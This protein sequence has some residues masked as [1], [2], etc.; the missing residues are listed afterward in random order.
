MLLLL[1]PHVPAC[2][3]S[4]LLGVLREQQDAANK[5]QQQF[6]AR[7]AEVDAQGLGAAVRQRVTAAAAHSP[8]LADC[9]RVVE[10]L[11]PLAAKPAFKAA[12]LEARAVGTLAKYLHRLV[13]PAVAPFESAESQVVAGQV[14]QLLAALC[15]ADVSLTPLAP[16]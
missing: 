3:L 16:R 13:A 6:R 5:A 8:Q 15:N 14:L 11:L 7:M 10:L 12:M 1:P 9:R 2:C 4:Q